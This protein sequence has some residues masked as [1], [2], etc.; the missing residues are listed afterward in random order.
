MSEFRESMKKERFE[1]LRDGHR[2]E[3]TMDNDKYFLSPERLREIFGLS[4]QE[5]IEQER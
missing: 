3:K 1:K 4:K 2:E 5:G